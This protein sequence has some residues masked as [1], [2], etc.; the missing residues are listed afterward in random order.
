MSHVDRSFNAGYFNKHDRFRF[1]LGEPGV[2]PGVDGHH[3]PHH[4]GHGLLREKREKNAEQR[5]SGVWAKKSRPH[6]NSPAGLGGGPEPRRHAARVPDEPRQPV[7]VGKLRIL[8][9][10]R[11]VQHQ[12]A[13][14]RLAVRGLALC[15]LRGRS[16]L[17]SGAI[18]PLR[19]RGTKKG[20]TKSFF[21][22]TRASRVLTLLASHTRKA[23]TAPL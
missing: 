12:D 20:L 10:V 11:L 16:R 9:Q 7:G 17:C 3:L 4:L 22:L 18:K 15:V 5:Y 23:P 1:A 19:R 21:H 13:G 14:D 2:A 6:L 8:G